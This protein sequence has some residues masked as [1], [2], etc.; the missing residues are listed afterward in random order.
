MFKRLMPL[1]V[2]AL[3]ASPALANDTLRKAFEARFGSKPEKITKTDYLGLYEIFADGRI[4]YTDEK[5]SAFFIGT[6]VDG[7]TMHNVTGRRLFAML[8]LELA[9]KQV[10][11]NGKATLV[12]FEDPNCGYCKK[13]A[14]DA[15]KLKDVT[16]YTFLFP[17]LSDDSTEKTKAI[18]CAEDRA[19]AWNAWMI[20]NKAPTGKKDCN[21]PIDKLVELGQRFDV[22]G[23]PTLL[24]A[25]GSRVPG[26]VP[27]A[28]IEQRL[29][30]IARKNGS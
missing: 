12:S 15:L 16:I 22:S 7:K 20:E 28:Q 2:A 24:F 19:K 27:V 21:A 9:V 3:L 23:T 29:A 26:A 11:G 18:W 5:A 10:R 1:I 17:I 13:L 8:P 4:I 30:E 14:K 6:L 25:D